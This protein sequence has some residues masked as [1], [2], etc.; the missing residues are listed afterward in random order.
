MNRYKGLA[1]ILMFLGPFYILPQIQG[2]PKS[3]GMGHFRT[4]ETSNCDVSQ[5]LSDIHQ[6]QETICSITSDQLAED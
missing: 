4:R 1:G 2:S 5:C 6:F 3:Q